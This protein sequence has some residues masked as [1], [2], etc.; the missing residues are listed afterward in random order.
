MLVPIFPQAEA[1][2]TDQHYLTVT[3]E[4]CQDLHLTL[5]EDNDSSLKVLMLRDEME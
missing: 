5:Q 2:Q 1:M 3:E 4:T